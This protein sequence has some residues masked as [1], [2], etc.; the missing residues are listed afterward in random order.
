MA[1]TAGR[2]SPGRSVHVQ[3][4]AELV[5]VP[6]LTVSLQVRVPGDRCRLN[7]EAD[8]YFVLQDLDPAADLV[9]SLERREGAGLQVVQLAQ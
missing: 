9:D 4:F 8:L 2:H 1:R 3:A 7:A 6:E 5:A